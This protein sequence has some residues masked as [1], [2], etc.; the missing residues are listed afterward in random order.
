[1]TQNEVSKLLDHAFTDTSK[2]VVVQVSQDVGVFVLENF[3][4]NGTM[5]VL[6]WRDVIVPQR[7]LS[8]S[9]DLS[10]SATD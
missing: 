8:T 1:M 3:K 10:T 7:K 9:V 4:R 2:H 5:V 6:E